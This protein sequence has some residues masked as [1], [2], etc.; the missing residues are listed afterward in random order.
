MLDGAYQALTKP[1]SELKPLTVVDANGVSHSL[2]VLQAEL[3]TFNQR[4]VYIQELAQNAQGEKLLAVKVAQDKLRFALQK[5]AATS[6]GLLALLKSSFPRIA[7]DLA[8]KLSRVPNLNTLLNDPQLVARINRLD[9]TKVDF[10]KG[11]GY[12]AT[13]KLTERDAFLFDLQHLPGQDRYGSLRKLIENGET[14]LPQGLIDNWRTMAANPTVRRRA[15]YL[16]EPD[17]GKLA[18]K[19]GRTNYKAEN[20]ATISR[21]APECTRCY[22]FYNQNGNI[23][24]NIWQ[25]A[26]A[27]YQRLG[28]GPADGDWGQFFSRFEAHHIFP[29]DLL[30][31]DV[32]NPQAKD[33]FIKYLTHYKGRVAEFND[34]ING[35]MLK[36]YSSTLG[37]TDGVHASHHQYTQKIREFL[38]G[39]YKKYS[40]QLS[41]DFSG[42][43][44]EEAIANKLH[45]DITKLQ[46]DLKVLLENKSILGNPPVKVNDLVNDTDFINLLK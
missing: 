28:K 8:E 26:Q 23:R 7:D 5:G 39:K 45:N 15:E 19:L 6:N 34:A 41:E 11:S 18:E 20:L 43:A 40:D 25:V 46:T 27:M 37:L 31:P 38:D 2:Q 35:I 14:D 42:N 13:D 16:L 3:A 1:L 36:K 21:L 44:L 22:Q 29:K 9:N 32:I 33:A 30:V 17:P 24:D 10:S 12:A 4:V